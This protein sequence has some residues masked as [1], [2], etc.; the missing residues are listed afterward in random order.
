MESG[1]FAADSGRKMSIRFC[2]RVELWY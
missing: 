1:Y 2:I